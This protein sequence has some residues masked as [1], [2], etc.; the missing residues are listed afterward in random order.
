MNVDI[1]NKLE[2]KIKDCLA[3]YSD[4]TNEANMPEG[5]FKA[6]ELLEMV[7]EAIKESEH[8]YEEHIKELIDNN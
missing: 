7:Y 6:M 2:I 3:E 8:R 5:F 1:S 4:S